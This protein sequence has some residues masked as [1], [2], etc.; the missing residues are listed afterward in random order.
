MKSFKQKPSI[1]TV[2]EGDYD[3]LFLWRI[4]NLYDGDLETI[5]F[6]PY[7]RGDEPRG[8]TQVLSNLKKLRDR[9][10]TDPLN[11][12]IGVYDSDFSKDDLV[13]EDFKLIKIDRCLEYL[14]LKIID[15]D[16][17][18]SH[19]NSADIKDL[20]NKRFNVSNKEDFKKF[21]ETEIT[22][23]KIDSKLETLKDL[24]ELV[25]IFN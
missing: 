12:Y 15:I 6:K 16:D 25:D 23:D 19:I 1:F 8:K 10:G 24:K 5:F 20:F 9:Y 21:L 11:S 7:P 18:D 17:C 2:S 4:Y 22:K 13:S 3:I 14:L